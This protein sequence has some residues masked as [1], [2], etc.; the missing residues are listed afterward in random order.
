MKVLEIS[1]LYPVPY[2]ALP[3][4]AMH[5]QIKTLKNK[6]C[7]V[8]VISPIPWTPFPIKY[9]S[10]KWRL[11]SKVSTHKIIEDIEIFYPRYLVFPKA[12]FLASSGIRMYYGIKKLVKKL[13]PIFPFD[14]IHAHMALPDGYAA[15]LLSRDYSKPLVI[16][17]QATDLDIT[18]NRN[19]KCL[20][21]LQKVFFA[22]DKVISPSPR[23][24]GQFSERFKIVSDIVGY[25][26]NSEDVFYGDSNLS[27][28]YKNYRVLLSV[29]RLIPTKGVD[30]NLYALKKIIAKY[31]NL[32]YLIIGDGPARQE[33]ECLVNDLGL[34]G[35]VK[36]IG[37]Q[38]HNRVMEYMSICNIF[39]MPS[40]QETF[41]LVYAEAMAHGKPIIGCQ[42]QGVDGIVTDGKTGLLVKPKDVDSLVKAIDY[43]LSNPDEARDI[44]ERAR[45]LV[46][47]NYTWEK[48]AEKT[49]EIYKEAL[50]GVH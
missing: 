24:S 16:T 28:K 7:E 37:Q 2:D 42:G 11:Y 34:K 20:Q 29:S 25:G 31:D 4:I 1:H 5:K 13:W 45:K 38:P 41:G 26:I 17:F 36:F 47:E 14:I 10:N 18:A 46:L 3:G 19:D 48:N 21:S 6:G 27:A 15:M 23:L 50:N 35:H 22:A 49:I 12:Y 9:M 39:S 43:L 32:L 8:L 40:W 33:L 44:G 30:L